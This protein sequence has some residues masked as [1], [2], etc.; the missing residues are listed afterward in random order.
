M[1][2]LTGVLKDELKAFICLSAPTPVAL[3]QH[4]T[5]TVTKATVS[6]ELMTVA[7]AL[8]ALAVD[9]TKA[10]A[11]APT[12]HRQPLETLVTLAVSLADAAV[13]E[14]APL[15]LPSTLSDLERGVVSRMAQYEL[16]RLKA[17]GA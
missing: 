13:R 8:E 7:L 11:A 2:A 16:E 1:N 12:T 4:A 10:N 6:R 14:N 3:Y 9:A 15:N 17:V 5:A